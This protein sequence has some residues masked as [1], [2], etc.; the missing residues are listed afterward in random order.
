LANTASA[1]KRI[2]Q[3]ERNRV[4]NRAHKSAVKTQTRRF[5]DAIQ[6][7]DLN[8]AQEAFALVQKKLD[9]VAAK[10]TLHRNTVARRKARLASR[11][12]KAVAAAGTG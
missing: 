11:L 2:K 6:G 8:A 1:K 3:N 5:L 7:G 9:Q 12:N 4:R 10:G